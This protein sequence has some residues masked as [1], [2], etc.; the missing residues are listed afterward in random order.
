MKKALFSLFEEH[1]SKSLFFAKK[2]TKIDQKMGHYCI[3]D[4]KRLDFMQ[5]A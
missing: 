4:G 2:L 3:F 5:S 1:L